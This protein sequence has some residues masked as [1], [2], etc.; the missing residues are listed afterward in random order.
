MWKT[1]YIV[2]SF[3]TIN[4]PKEYLFQKSLQ[5]Y[6]VL[7]EFIFSFQYD[8]QY[9]TSTDKHR[10]HSFYQTIS[11]PGNALGKYYHGYMRRKLLCMSHVQNFHLVC[12][13]KN[14][15]CKL[16]LKKQVYFIFQQVWHT[17]IQKA[18]TDLGISFN[19]FLPNVPVIAETLKG[20][21]KNTCCENLELFRFCH[22]RPNLF[23][24]TWK[25]SHFYPFHANGLFL[26]PLKTP[27][28]QRFYDIFLGVQKEANGMKLVETF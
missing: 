8:Y 16:K 18:N 11:C 3:F 14:S 19:L 5:L 13:R 10:H 15:Y 28:N 20:V 22:L 2:T 6:R 4:L 9:Y 26:H 27:E 23:V 1:L 25:A 17:N 24:K 12:L 7:S 21:L